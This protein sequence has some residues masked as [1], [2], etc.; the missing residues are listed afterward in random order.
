M[1]VPD[2]HR[3]ERAKDHLERAVGYIE[4]VAGRQ[5]N[6]L[7]PTLI[8]FISDPI[9]KE[10]ALLSDYIEKLNNNCFFEPGVQI[11]VS[12]NDQP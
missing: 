5:D 3:L 4:K 10:M 6:N 2:I 9:K 7:K 12:V 8:L 1:T 11:E